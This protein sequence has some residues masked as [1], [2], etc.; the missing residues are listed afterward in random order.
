MFV[1]RLGPHLGDRFEWQ[2][3]TFV[4]RIEDFEIAAFDFDDH[5]QLRAEL[6]LVSIVFRS[7]IDEVADVDRVCFQFLSSVGGA[8]ELRYR[9]QVD[10]CIL[11]AGG[12]VRIAAHL[13]SPEGHCQCVINQEASDERFAD[14]QY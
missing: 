6:E 10:F 14:F 7:T 8:Y 5:P 4:V 12:A 9:L 1:V 2:P 3:V 13:E 11:T